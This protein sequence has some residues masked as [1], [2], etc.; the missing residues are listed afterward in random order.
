MM[1]ETKETT[2]RRA[3]L[4]GLAALPVAAAMIPASANA[5]AAS[6]IPALFSEWEAL[7]DYANTTKGLTDKDV[8]EV[9]S[10]CAE[11]EARAVALTPATAT[12]YAMV[13]AMVTVYFDEGPPFAVASAF[14]AQLRRLLGGDA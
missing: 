1:T 11:L 14:Q 10:R 9:L 5:G 13:V 7:Q 4:A 3:A 6:E 8:G 2:T 12:E